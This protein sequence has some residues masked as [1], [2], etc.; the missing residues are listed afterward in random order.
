VTDHHQPNQPSALA[1]W[2]RFFVGSPRRFLITAGAI[3][4]LLFI[5]APTTMGNALTFVVMRIW[6]AFEAPLSAALTMMIML[7]GVVVIWRGVFPKKREKNSR[8]NRH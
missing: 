4:L 8:N 7:L 3:L 2:G 5:A 6:I 1:V